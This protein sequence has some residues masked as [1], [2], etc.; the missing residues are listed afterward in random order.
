VNRVSLSVAQPR[1]VAEFDEI[2]EEPVRSRAS[3]NG[4]ETEGGKFMT[5]WGWRIAALALALTVAAPA[6][7]ETDCNAP[8]WQRFADP[9]LGFTSEVSTDVHQSYRIDE[10]NFLN[11]D[12]MERAR[13][14]GKIDGRCSSFNFTVMDFS[15][16][17]ITDAAGLVKAS[18]DRIASGDLDNF[19]VIRNRALTF[20]GSPAR[21]VIF[22]FT[23]D[24]FGT[25]ATHRYLIVA[26][27]NRLYTFGWV[28]GDDGAIP[29]DSARISD[30][31]RFTQAS[32]DPNARSRA[33]LEE[34]ILLYWL[35]DEYPQTV[36]MSKSLRQIADPKRAAES[37]MIKAYGYV[38]KVDYLRTEG[39]YR[40]FRVEHNDAVI[41]WFTMDNG[42]QITSLYWKKVRDL[43]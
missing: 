1:A 17:R 13:P 31:I 32:A 36:F 14:G 15:P 39:G 3:I 35:R 16:N 34:T 18:A 37:K 10:Q 12:G 4:D 29:A 23:I 2:G 20:Q 21:E 43:K 11:I 26:R 30:S 8:Q 38:Q 19:K 9:T 24:F 33:M 40:V 41:D 7:A 28:W 6:S 25:P 22:S 42:S 5:K 27:D